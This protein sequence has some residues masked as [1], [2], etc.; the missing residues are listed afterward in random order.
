[1]TSEQSALLQD[2]CMIG[3]KQV[4]DNLLILLFDILKGTGFQPSL[5]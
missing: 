1:M 2:K 4:L 3:H 5:E